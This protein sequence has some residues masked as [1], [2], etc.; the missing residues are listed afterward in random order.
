MSQ[1]TPPEHFTGTWT[2]RHPSGQIAEKIEYKNG[3][4][5]GMRTTRY[6]NLENTLK[7]EE[8]WENSRRVGKWT[9]WYDDVTHQVHSKGSWKDGLPDGPAIH[10]HPNGVRKSMH[11]FGNG[12]NIRDHKRWDEEGKLEY[13]EHYARGNLTTAEHFAN[14]KLKQVDVYDGQ[15]LVKVQYIENGNDVRETDP[16]PTPE[17]NC[18]L[19]VVGVYSISPT[20]ASISIAAKYHHLDRLLDAGG[21]FNETIRWESHVNL[22]L[23]E[24]QIKGDFLPRELMLAISMNGQAPYMEFY[25]DAQGEA[26][27]SE[28]TAVA[29]PNRRVCFFLHFVTANKPLDVAGRPITLPSEGELPNRL[30]DFTHYMPVD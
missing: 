9:S 10:W 6:D 13:V 23:V 14:G 8:H 15:D 20:L 18:E 2:I 17:L 28:E 12:I 25:L 22:R 26:L 16:R 11:C 29:T 24:I 5:H 4:W 1:P 30:A 7:S 19:H 3:K 27:L 21:R